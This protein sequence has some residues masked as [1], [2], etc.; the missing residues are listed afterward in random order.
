MTNEELARRYNTGEAIA[1]LAQAAGMSVG[2]LHQRLRRIG[3][4]PRRRPDRAASLTNQEIADALDAHRSISA[5]ARAL[6]VDR[7]ALT[8]AARRHQLLP[9]PTLPA[10]LADRYRDGATIAQLARDHHTS[11]SVIVGW[12]DAAGVARR[13]RGRPTRDG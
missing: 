4:P 2:G 7:A 12:L 3:V 1:E 10:D 11:T 8:A 5:A 6:G 13:P 9:A